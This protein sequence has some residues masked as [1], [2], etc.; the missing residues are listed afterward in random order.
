M[1]MIIAHAMAERASGKSGQPNITVLDECWSLLDS[2]VLA[3]QVE[4]LFRT[5]RKRG[6]SVWGI[7]QA[8]E[9]FVGTDAH[10]RTHGPGIVKNVST[11]I[12][13]QQ[14]GDLKP[15]AA[16]LHLNQTALNEIRGFSAPRKGKKAQA[17]LVLGE[18]A[19]TTQTINIVPTPLQYWICTTFKR[20]RMYRSWFLHTNRA[21]PLLRAYEML[22]SKFP[23]G[24]A[25][26]PE[27]PEEL[28]GA[29]NAVAA[30]SR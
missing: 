30:A 7:S 20:E 11:K 25:D 18:K 16:Y 10:P 8:L 6:A 24:L 5:G 17:L 27:L 1:S 14:Q 3:P 2:A 4:Q 13:G 22:A 28:S 9:D 21:I 26:V 23:S 15:L 29:V 19:E 12:I